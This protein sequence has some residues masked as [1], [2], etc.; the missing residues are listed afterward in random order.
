[1]ADP[2]YICFNEE[3]CTLWEN[4]QDQTV[5]VT[6]VLE[7]DQ[8]YAVT[9]TVISVRYLESGLNHPSESEEDMSDEEMPS[10]EFVKKIPTTDNKNHVK[11]DGSNLKPSKSRPSFARSTKVR[12]RFLSPKNIKERT[13]EKEYAVYR[14]VIRK[15]MLSKSISRNIVNNCHSSEIQGILKRFFNF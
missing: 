12:S 9:L 1:M 2:Q 11:K 5:K 4:Y 3:K 10:L 13:I 8:R 6:P 14:E 15:E 7:E